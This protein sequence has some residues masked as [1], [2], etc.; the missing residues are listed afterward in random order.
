M[1][2]GTIATTGEPHIETTRFYADTQEI[3]PGTIVKEIVT[4]FEVDP[5]EPCY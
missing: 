3:G 5:T 2:Q 1:R 4:P